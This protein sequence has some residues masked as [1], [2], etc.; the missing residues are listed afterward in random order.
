[1][2]R[3]NQLFAS[4]LRKC[5]HCG[6]ELQVIAAM[7][8]PGVITRILEYIGVLGR[9]QPCTPPSALAN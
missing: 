3:L 6:R 4:D 9:V 2:A 1:M 8:E 7:T 5:S